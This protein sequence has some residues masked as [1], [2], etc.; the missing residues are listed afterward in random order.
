M[1]STRDYLLRIPEFARKKHSLKEAEAFLEELGCP[2]PGTVIHVAGTNGKGSVCAFLASILRAS[3]YCVGTFTSPHLE[4]IRER[5]SLNG[6]P[7]E[8]KAFQSSFRRVKETWEQMEKGGMTHPTFFE[9]LF[10][11]AAACFYEKKPDFVILE[12]GMGGRTDVTNV[13]RPALCVITSVSLDHM[14]YLGNTVEEIAGEKAGIIKA[15]APVIFDG[16]DRAAAAVIRK[17]AETAGT[18]CTDVRDLEVSAGWDGAFPVITMPF[19][20]GRVKARLPFPADYQVRNAAAAVKAAELLAAGRE[21]IGAASVSAGLERTRHQGRMEEVLPG[22]Y[23]DGAHNRDGILAFCRAAS[24]IARCAGKR[25]RLLFSA[26]SDKEYGQMAEELLEELRPEEIFLAHM[27][28]GRSLTE[29][30]LEQAFRQADCPVRCFSTVRSALSAALEARGEDL[31]FA[32][33]S[34]YFMG[35][36]KECL[37]E[38]EYDKFR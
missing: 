24:R 30:Q 2:F 33:G 29:G 25:I 14:A 23:L 28:S 3:G 13:C 18:E 5:I 1:E 32:A 6:E 10:Y 36:L 34:L 19:G 17:A 11:M 26:V 22:V 21:G 37:K 8:E 38:D 9:Y 20:C 31:L 7:I 15:G 4:D 27:E 16:N 35:E 12:T